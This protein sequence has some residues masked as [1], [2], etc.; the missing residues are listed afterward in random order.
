[1]SSR[2]SRGDGGLH[3]D[4]SRQRWVATATVGYDG[5]GKRLVRQR[6][7]YRTCA[8]GCSSLGALSRMPNAVPLA[9]NGHETGLVFTTRFG[10]AMDAANVRRDFRRALASVPGLNPEDWTPRELRHS[11][12]S[13]LSDA[14][15]PIED[16]SRLVGH[17]STSVT[18]L[19]YRH[20]IR[21]VIQSGATIMDRLFGSP[22][23]RR[24]AEALTQN[25]GVKNQAR[26]R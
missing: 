13:L 10:T 24:A 17:S 7:H 18:E 9:S 14:G 21:P 2:R 1:M 6:S 19:V 3:W 25:N 11:F 20:Q 16:V 5:R 15:V 23:D 8:L 12:V 22:A 4:Q 26:P